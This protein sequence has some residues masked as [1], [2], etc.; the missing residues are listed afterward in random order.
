MIGSKIIQLEERVNQMAFGS[1]EERAYNEGRVEERRQFVHF[2]HS[3]PRTIQSA[4]ME[5]LDLCD[6]EGDMNC[7]YEQLMKKEQEC[8]DWLQIHLGK[9]SGI[10]ECN[11][12]GQVYCSEILMADHCVR[13]H[14][15]QTE[16]K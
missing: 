3:L 4:I 13:N 6:A 7:W 9:G 2:L 15:S 12:C 8:E 1:K 5:C 10:M 16:K 11:A 14:T